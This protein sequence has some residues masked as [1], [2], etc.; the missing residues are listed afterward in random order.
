[1]PEIK[2]F[3]AILIGKNIRKARKNKGISISVL[4]SLC[5]ISVGKLSNLENGKTETVST[6]DLE[7]I[8]FSLSTSID[9]I[10]IPET[11]KFPSELEPVIDELQMVSTY[12][13]MNLLDLARE[14]LHKI[15]KE[16]MDNQLDYLRPCINFLAGEIEKLSFNHDKAIEYFKSVIDQNYD[17]IYGI[18]YKIRSINALSCLYY[19][20]F[21][22]A[23]ALDTCLEAVDLINHEGVSFSEIAD[24]HYNLAIF[25]TYAGYLSVALLHAKSASEITATNHYSNYNN[26]VNYLTG[27][28]LMQRKEYI[29]AFNFIKESSTYFQR[30]KDL[31]YLYRCIYSLYLIIDHVP[32]T[33]K[34]LIKSLEHGI[35]TEFLENPIHNDQIHIQLTMIHEIIENLILSSDFE[36]ALILLNKCLE[37]KKL[38]PSDRIHF[39][40]HHLLSIIS[41]KNNENT[42]LIKQ[43]LHESLKYLSDENSKDRAMILYELATLLNQCTSPYEESSRIFYELSKKESFYKRPFSVI[44]P[45]PKY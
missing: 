44:I 31:K 2:R 39:K 9:D 34:K 20:R 26:Q 40:T 28:I 42:N 21:E 23:E 17:Y 29:K 10:I 15:T 25:Y 35:T 32:F 33:E 14:N 24:T 11:F 4:S 43:H 3:D 30:E 22:V 16:L 27:I 19:S 38:I 36:Q 8:A 7:K 6:E 45:E 41:K 18:G 5:K 12:I 37:Y 1:M 13:S